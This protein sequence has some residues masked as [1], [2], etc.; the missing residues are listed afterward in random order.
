MPKLYEYQGKGL[1]RKFMPVPEGDVASS[2]EDARRIAER[3]GKP[4]VIKAQ[5]GYGI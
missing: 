5:V 2:A 4:V 1:L 3:L